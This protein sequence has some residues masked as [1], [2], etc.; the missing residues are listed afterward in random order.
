MLTYSIPKWTVD[1]ILASD[2]GDTPD[3]YPMHQACL[4]P[5]AIHHI[6]N[7][8]QA[9]RIQAPIASWE[10]LGLWLKRKAYTDH[11]AFTIEAHEA[12]RRFTQSHRILHEIDKVAGHPAYRGL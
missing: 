11:G 4:N 2:F 6:G 7:P 8:R 1:L 9:T 5:V 10:A 12:K 3:G